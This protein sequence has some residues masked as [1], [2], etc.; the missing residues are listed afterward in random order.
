MYICIITDTDGNETVPMADT[1]KGPIPLIAHTEEQLQAILE[2]AKK[3]SAMY[4]L[5]VTVKK[6]AEGKEVYKISTEAKVEEL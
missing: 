5:T 6:F 1:S 3:V 4:D 2:P